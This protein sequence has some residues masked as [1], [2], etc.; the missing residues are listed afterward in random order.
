MSDPMANSKNATGRLTPSL[1]PLPGS[2]VRS[3]N[4]GRS[5]FARLFGFVQ[6]KPSLEEGHYP[7][8]RVIDD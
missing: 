8:I 6:R 3:A 5:G 1:A 7:G 2:Y 4:A